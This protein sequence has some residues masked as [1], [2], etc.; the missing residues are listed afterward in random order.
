[1]KPH[2]LPVNPQSGAIRRGSYLQIIQSQKQLPMFT[3]CFLPVAQLHLAAGFATHPR[4]EESNI[5]H[6]FII[7]PDCTGTILLFVKGR[8][9]G[10]SCFSF[11]DFNCLRKIKASLKFNR[12][13]RSL[14]K[15]PCCL[16]R[17]NSSDQQSVF[18]IRAHEQ[19][20]SSV[21]FRSGALLRRLTP[22][23]DHS[24]QIRFATKATMICCIGKQLFN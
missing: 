13:N 9:P 5:R 21:Y 14:V 16:E 1:M 2:T 11:I 22:F 6:V 19:G 17:K 24:L 18:K 12:N 4:K 3:G 10:R 23:G 8:T 15:A 7:N 20:L